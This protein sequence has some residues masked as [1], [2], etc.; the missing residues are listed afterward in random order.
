M[1]LIWQ[2]CNVEWLLGNKSLLVMLF[3]WLVH[4]LLLES[5]HVM[6]LVVTALCWSLLWQL[7]VICVKRNRAD[8]VGTA[9]VWFWK[10]EVLKNLFPVVLYQCWSSPD[11]NHSSTIFSLYTNRVLMSF[12]LTRSLKADICIVPGRHWGLELVVSWELC[13]IFCTHCS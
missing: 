2:L 5:V 13:M 9:V 1:V 7:L 3:T 8:K 12:V 11:W 4:S 10:T 6:L